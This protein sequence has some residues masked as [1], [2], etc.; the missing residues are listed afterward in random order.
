MKRVLITGGFGFVGGRLA[1]HLSSIGYCVFLGS[2]SFKVVPDWLPEAE[3]VKISWDDDRELSRICNEVDIIVH[4][5]GMNV[6]DCMSDP[7]GA[8]IFNG[9]AT[10]RLARIAERSGVSKFIY[11]STAHIYGSQLIGSI[12][13]DNFPSNPHPYAT[14]HLVGEKAVLE[15]GLFSHMSSVVLR[16][17]NGFGVPAHK[18]T[19]CWKLLANDVCRQAVT[20]RK[21][22][23]KSDGKQYRDFI[24]LTAICDVIGR[25]LLTNLQKEMAPI[26]N[27]GSGVSFRVLDF[28]RLIQDR[29]YLAL[30]YRPQLYLNESIDNEQPVS[31]TYSCNALKKRGISVKDDL[32]EE[33]D[34]LIRYCIDCL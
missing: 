26:F 18:A 31:F 32:L 17:S 11:L 6:S 33:I 10:A 13:E 29:C 15:A 16:L 9:F 8:F 20:T 12:S 19:P 2:R 7:I 23:L 4:A 28:T 14:S 22:I 3:V 27:V 34:S 5:A 21:I 1:Q 30:G 24:S 25:I